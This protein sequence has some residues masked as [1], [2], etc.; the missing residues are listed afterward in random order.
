MRRR[1]MTCVL[2]GTLLSSGTGLARGQETGTG[3]VAGRVT[4]PTGAVLPGVAVEA[5]PEGGGSARSTGTDATGDYRIDGLAAGAWELSF[6]LPNFASAVLHDVVVRPGEEARLD[7]TLELRFA[8]QVMVSAPATFRDLSTVTSDSE[9]IGI[10]TS[11]ST[12]VVAGSQIQDRPV[13]RPG[14]LAE[15][16][17][18]VVISQHSGEGKANQYYV[19]G[20]NIDHGTD[21]ALSVAGMPVNLPT[22]GHGQGYADLNFVIPE[23][24]GSIQYKKGTY[25]ADEGDF[26][27]AGAIHM[28]YLDVLDRPIVKVEGGG[29]GYRR[30]LFAVSPRLG[31]GHLLAAF[32]LGHN[33]GPW[34][35]PDDFRKINGVLRYSRGTAQSGLSLAAMFYDAEWDSTDQV[36]VRAIESGQI[37]RFGHVDPTDGGRSHRH[38]LCAAWQRGSAR[39]LTRVE[40][41]VAEYGLDL[42][43]NFTLLPRRPR[44]RRPVRAAGRPVAHRAAGEPALGAGIGPADRAHRGDAAAVRRHRA[45]GPLR[46]EDARGSPPPART[47]SAR[48]ARPST[49]RPTPSGRAR[50]APSSACGETSTRSTWTRATRS[51]RVRRPPPGPAPSSRWPS[52]RG[53]APRSMPTTG[54]ASTAMTPAGP[55]SPAIPRPGSR[56]SRWT[57]SSGRGARSW[58]CARSRRR[59]FTRPPRCGG[60]TSTR[61]SSSSAMPAPPSRAV[62]AGAAASS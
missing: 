60:S 19:R 10:A 45:G 28:N 50:C 61:S 57:L 7:R 17:P 37:P 13:A 38:S 49:S 34:V 55:R 46:H 11:A 40:G 8:A 58:A 24:V 21:L 59:A 48:A 9:L 30:A 6:Q 32:E 42:F 51:T 47:T 3:A 20:F 44:E 2:L 4:D 18:G 5:R 54:G 25:Y 14:D 62:P 56:P 22:N 12:G 43:S 23:L 31:S 33:D 29:Y 27:A 52:V 39:S 36:P 16:V 35:R 1:G 26:S 53:R 41:F 15:R